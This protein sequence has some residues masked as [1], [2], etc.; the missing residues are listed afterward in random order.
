MKEPAATTNAR[1]EI[2]GVSAS[3]GVAIGPVYVHDPGEAPSPAPEHRFRRG[4]SRVA[5][6]RAGST[7]RR[8]PAR[9]YPR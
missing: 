3:E 2:T 7:G 6:L 5:A 8:R 1:E 4:G 9:S